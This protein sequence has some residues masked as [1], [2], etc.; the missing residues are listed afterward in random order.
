MC[1]TAAVSTKVVRAF[2]LSADK[3]R[4]DQQGLGS[5]KQSPPPLPRWCDPAAKATRARV[6]VKESVKGGRGSSKNIVTSALR[7]GARRAR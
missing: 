4:K 5:P 6:Q 1:N 2:S 3:K 7:K